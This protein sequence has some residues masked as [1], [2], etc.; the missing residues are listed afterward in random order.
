MYLFPQICLPVLTV[1]RIC[2]TA[3]YDHCLSAAELCRYAAESVLQT[4]TC[5]QL[6]LN[7]RGRC[8]KEASY[9]TAVKFQVVISLAEWGGVFLSF[10]R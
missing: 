10:S 1:R 9:L 4:R 7:G 8:C 3:L 5:A 6:E 2:T